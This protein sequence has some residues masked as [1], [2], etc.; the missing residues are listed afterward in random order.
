[1]S[2]AATARR[3][4]PTGHL[5]VFSPVA[6]SGPNAKAK[7][8]GFHRSTDRIVTAACGGQADATSRRPRDLRQGRSGTKSSLIHAC[9]RVHGNGHLLV[10]NRGCRH[11]LRSCPHVARFEAIGID[12]TPRA[13]VVATTN[14]ELVI[15]AA[16]VEPVV[17]ETPSSSSAPR[18]GQVIVAASKC[19]VSSRH[20]FEQYPRADA[21]DRRRHRHGCVRWR[22]NGDALAIVPARRYMVHESGLAPGVRKR[23]DRRRQVTKRHRRPG[24]RGWPLRA[25]WSQAAGARDAYPGIGQKHS[26][27]SASYRYNAAGRRG[28]RSDRR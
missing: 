22:D 18:P 13:Q 19:S 11:R 20:R 12:A 6:S 7:V 25:A 4:P 5:G 10:A 28:A 3:S 14:Y 27:V 26:T 24:G 23:H 21:E 9:R 15:P 16:S 17:A 8:P 1:M 2:E